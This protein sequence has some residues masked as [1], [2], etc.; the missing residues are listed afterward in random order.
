MTKSPTIELAEPQGRRARID[1][2]V[3]NEPNKHTAR[4][5][6]VLREGREDISGEL[7]SISVSISL[8]QSSDRLLETNEI[9]NNRSRLSRS[10]SFFF[11]WS[12][13]ESFSNLLLVRNLVIPFPIL[14]PGQRSVA[15]SLCNPWKSGSCFPMHPF[16]LLDGIL[17][18]S[19]SLRWGDGQRSIICPVSFSKI[20]RSTPNIVIAHSF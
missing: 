17:R 2:T 12:D 19:S 7:K 5:P 9:R 20:P 8:I 10:P 18:R 13:R 4:K 11:Y 1:Q 6:L 14:F 3:R 15:T 16:L